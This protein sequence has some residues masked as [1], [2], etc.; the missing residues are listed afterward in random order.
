MTEMGQTI[1]QLA[2]AAGVNRQ[3]VRYYQRRGLLEQPPRPAHGYRRYEQAALE[4]LRFIKRAQALGFTLDEIKHLLV[5]S[6]GRCAGV[7]ARHRPSAMT[8][9]GAL[10]TSRAYAA[11]WMKRSPL[12]GGATPT[13]IAR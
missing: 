10:M 12:A 9:I 1:G 13:P 4:R 7:Q 3:T 5:L 8:S 11:R 2:A 6:D